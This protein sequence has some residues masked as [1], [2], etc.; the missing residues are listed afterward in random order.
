MRVLYLC[1]NGLM[2]PLGQSQVL[3]Y[4]EKLAAAHRVT[5]VTFEK[6]ADLA[7]ADAMAA[8]RARCEVAGIR[9]VARRYH[10][11]P[12]MLA[13]LAD[14]AMFLATAWGEARRGGAE[15]IHCRSYIPCF[16][17]LAI[18]WGLRLP[19]IFDMRGFWPDE[20]VSAGRLR[21]GALVYR[22]LKRAE[23]LC[24]RRAAAVVSL[25]EA[26]A[27]H[28]AARDGPG[29]AR[30]VVIPTCVDVE[31]FRP[32]PGRDPAAAPVLFGTT[33][34]VVGGWFRL[35]WL[36]AFWS[37][38]LAEFGD[39]RFRIVS[40]DSP[41]TIRQAGAAWPDVLARLEIGGR[42]HARM[43][44]AVAEFDVAALFYLS[45]FSEIA[46]CPT[47]MGEMLA[48]GCPV[49]ANDSA[50]DVGAIIGRYRVGVVV[51]ENT[52]E[53]MRRA[54]IELAALLGDPGLAERCRAAA[55]NWFALGKGV[56]RYDRL[57][58]QVG[59]TGD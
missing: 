56:A 11:R 41:E 31:R 2:E 13:T 57:Y 53:A 14:L 8:M 19:F 17:A 55:E 42:E 30:H 26:A 34:T 23:G 24:L 22:L 21:Q 28:L 48:C 59:E 12:R 47:R 37:A 51:P 39:I 25:T 52:P 10:H 50:G 45:G 3:A 49:V 6:P 4:L 1:Y 36:F 43:P 5:L 40:R 38:A 35:D 58:R 9:W 54:A 18:G 33:G 16:V 7:R 44:A 32:R 29:R 46:R 27:A 20:M 15:L